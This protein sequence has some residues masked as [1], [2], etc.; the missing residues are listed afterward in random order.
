MKVELKTVYTAEKEIKRR[1]LVFQR[2]ALIVMCSV[3]LTLGFY[4]AHRYSQLL[5]DYH[6]LQYRVISGGKGDGLK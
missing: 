2:N 1:S 6:E 4:A 3:A 5:Q